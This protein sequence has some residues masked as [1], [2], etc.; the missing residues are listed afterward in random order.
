M[1]NEIKKPYLLLLRTVKLLLSKKADAKYLDDTKAA[2]EKQISGSIKSVNGTK[3]DANGNVEV[4][5]GS[6]EVYILKDGE[7]LNDVP[8]GVEVVYDLDN[9]SGDSCGNYFLTD[10][11]IAKIAELAQ[12]NIDT[13]S[14]YILK[15]GETIDDAPEDADFV[16]DPKNEGK[17]VGSG[18]GSGMSATAINLLIEVLES[19][20]YSTN[21]SGK[22][23]SLKEALLAGGS[24]GGDTG[25]DTG[26]GDMPDNP[27]EPDEPVVP[28]DIT[29]SGGVM[30]IISVG[31]EIAVSG[32]V[33][34]IA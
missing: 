33:M 14:M 19:A 32:G 2:L 12:K 20:V 7:T 9:D 24:G 10:D 6:D 15:P 23:A 28:D 34:T 31:S 17:G 29:V 13:V 21:V 8:D 18:G 4:T 3:P 30:T 22:I 5:V 26:G 27:V 11:D 16:Y 25:G 1:K